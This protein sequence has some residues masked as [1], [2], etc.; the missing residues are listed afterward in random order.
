MSSSPDEA[1]PRTEWLDRQTFYDALDRDADDEQYELV[2]RIYEYV[3]TAL[4]R[5]EDAAR[6]Q[7]A[8]EARRQP[9]DA[10]SRICRRYFSSTMM[11]CK[12]HGTDLA[13]CE[14]WEAGATE[15]RRELDVERLARADWEVFGG[16]RASGSTWDDLDQRTKDATLDYARQVAAEYRSLIEED[17]TP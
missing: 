15:A 11:L 14:D 12:R 8:T 10:A 9:V 4:A 13:R 1:G 17:V 3:R 2:D 5:I 6:E 16:A 7:A